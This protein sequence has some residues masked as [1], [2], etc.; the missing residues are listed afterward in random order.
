MQTM[1]V[2]NFL[3]YPKLVREWALQ[4]EFL[5]AEQYSIKYNAKTDWPGERSD[6]VYDLDNEYGDNVLTAVTTIITRLTGLVNLG[7]KSYF[8][9]T[10][11]SDG[12]SWVHQDNDTDYA[13][14]LYLNPNVPPIYG[15]TIYQCNNIPKWQSYMSTAEGYN[16]LKTINELENV[17]LYREIFTPTD[18]IGN[19]FNRL[20]I[21]RG[22]AY[23]KSTK[24]F[25][26]T[27]EDARLTQV[28]FIKQNES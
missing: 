17:E 24:Y 15:T 1:I 7:V 23:H 9:I 28:F 18:Y 19:V 2:D 20:V 12:G 10:R 6:H 26:T 11:E 3:P 4:Q 5:N 27:R 13:A 14:I 16:I 25:G 22:D 21:Y 8:Q